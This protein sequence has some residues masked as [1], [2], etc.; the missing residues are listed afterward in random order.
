VDV[1]GNRFNAGGSS[2]AAMVVSAHLANV[3]AS[4]T[5]RK[6]PP[7]QLLKKLKAAFREEMVA[8][9]DLEERLRTALR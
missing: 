5:G 7:D 8:A 2:T 1:D 9:G 3:L 4:G 6:L